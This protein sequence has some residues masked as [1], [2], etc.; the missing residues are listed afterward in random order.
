MTRHPPRKLIRTG[1]GA[2]EEG[3]VFL[4]GPLTVGTRGTIRYSGTLNVD[5]EDGGPQFLVW[6]NDTFP[7]YFFIP[8]PNS[9]WFTQYYFTTPKNSDIIKNYRLYSF[10]IDGIEYVFDE[11]SSDVSNPNQE[12]INYRWSPP[13]PTEG[14][15]NMDRVNILDA[16]GQ[17]FTFLLLVRPE[18]NAV[19]TFNVMKG[20][21]KVASAMFETFPEDIDGS[22]SAVVTRKAGKFFAKDG[23]AP[24]K[25]LITFIN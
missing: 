12:L 7:N 9:V 25:D 14:Y 21:S 11:D 2:A 15:I 4:P 18:N 16:H 19:F 20:S 22:G 24:R 5:I 3:R 8:P 1:F 17:A 23:R 13:P 10:D 6:A